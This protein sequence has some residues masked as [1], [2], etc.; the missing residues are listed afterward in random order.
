M[1]LFR[2]QGLIPSRRRSAE[3]EHGGRR[4]LPLRRERIGR[5]DGCT[6]PLP[7]VAPALRV[8]G[9]QPARGARPAQGVRRPR[10]RATTSTS[11]SRAARSSSLIGPNGA[12]KTTFFNMLTGVYTPT[13]GEIVFDGD[14][15]AGLPPHAITG[16]R[17][18]PHVPEH[19]ALPD[20]D[21]ARERDGR[22]ALPAAAAA[23]CRL[24][25]A[26][27]RPA[28]GGARG[29]RQG[30]RAARASSAWRGGSTRSSPATCPTA[31]SAGSR[32]RGRWPPTRSCCCS[33]SRPPA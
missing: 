2:P 22:H 30:A 27:A 17:H 31:T 9:R 15:V 13:A 32:S 26:H 1:M 4:R 12:G 5:S 10:R 20:D 28:P 3:F 29:P 6:S 8:V 33:T 19:P 25:P 21:R 23:S 24:D 7:S 16:A 14:E 18:R 11:R